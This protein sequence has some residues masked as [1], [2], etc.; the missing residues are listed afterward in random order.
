MFACFVVIPLLSVSISHTYLKENVRVFENP[1]RVSNAIYYIGLILL[2]TG[3]ILILIKLNADKLFK[4]IIFFLILI[5]IQYVL[6]P[7][8]PPFLALALAVSLS[9]ILYFWQSWLIIDAVGIMLA[10]GITA[11]FGISLSPI[12][13]VILLAILA[14]YDYLSV[15]RT[16]HMIS[17]AEAVVKLRVPILLIFPFRWDFSLKDDINEMKESGAYFLGLGD[18]IIPSILVVSANTFMGGGN[19]L[20]NVHALSALAGTVAGF[21]A[22]MISAKIRGGAHPGLP[23][24]NGGAIFGFFISLIIFQN[25]P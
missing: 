5:S 19:S 15:Y 4:A 22:M 23:F 14:I 10:V 1:E 16:G 3:I 13:A 9:L 6:L 8:M 18:L 2:F 25:L 17:L 12:P 20:L 11:I 7:F 21:I 24:L